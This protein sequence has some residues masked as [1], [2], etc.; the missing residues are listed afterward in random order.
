MTGDPTAYVIRLN[1]PLGGGNP[2]TGVAPTTAQNGDHITLGVPGGAVGGGNFS[3][4]M[5][6][7]QGDVEHTGETSTHSVLA[8]DYA[9]VKTRFFKNTTSPVT[10]T[11]DYS[12]FYDVDGSGS[13]LA[14]DFAE[15]K[16]R[17]F[18]NL[19]PATTTASTQSV[20][21]AS[22]TKDLFGNTAIL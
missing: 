21:A 8:N 11:N 17:F 13:I 18:Q 3:L 7:L 2:A 6:V 12:S 22:A 10:G 14:T 4:R 15:V 20:A 16:K 19:A 1:Q 5:D 9:A